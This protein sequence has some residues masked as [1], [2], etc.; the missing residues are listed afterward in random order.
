MGRAKLKKRG[1]C[2]LPELAGGLDPVRK[3]IFGGRRTQQLVVIPCRFRICRRLHLIGVLRLHH[4]AIVAEKAVFLIHVI[5]LL[6][7]QVGQNFSRIVSSGGLYG[8]EVLQ[9]R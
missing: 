5:A 1:P 4:L 6:F 8:T 9:R 7:T 3:C 2:L